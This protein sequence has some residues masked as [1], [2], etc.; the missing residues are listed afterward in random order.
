M[1]MRKSLLTIA[2][3]AF[4]L[5]GNPFAVMAEPAIEIVELEGGFNDITVTISGTD[6]HVVNAHGET[7]QIYNVA[8]VCVET[9]KIDGEDKHYTLNLSKGCYIVKVGK[10]VRK[11]S[12]K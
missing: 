2:C 10:I 7:L 9:I 11:I 5:L 3:S 4:F 12:I 1:P 8:G 6:L